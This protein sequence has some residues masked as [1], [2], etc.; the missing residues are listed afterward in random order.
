MENNQNDTPKTR[1]RFNVIDALILLV[2]LAFVIGLAFRI[3]NIRSLS[4]TEGLQSYDVYFS[5]TNLASTTEDYLDVGDSLVLADNRMVLG[6]L[7]KID[8]ATPSV[9]YS[10]GGEG[11]IVEVS[12]P[13]DTRIDLTGVI[14]SHGVMSERGYLLNGTTYIAPGMSY[15]VQSERVDF[16]L[17]ITKIVE[18]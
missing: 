13:S 9:F 8:P 1:F 7:S 14:L 2:A 11:E 15:T 4:S 5:V 6:T 17:T 18:R 10:H 12:Y 16:V 3:G